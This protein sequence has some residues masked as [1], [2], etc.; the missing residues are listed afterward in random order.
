[1]R[2]SLAAKTCDVKEDSTYERLVSIRVVEV[3][4]P[5]RSRYRASTSRLLINYVQKKCREGKPLLRKMFLRD[6]ERDY[7]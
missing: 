5:L 3:L 7:F 4:A 6:R 2:V 1:M